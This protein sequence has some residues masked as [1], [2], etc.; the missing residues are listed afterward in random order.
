MASGGPSH[1]SILDE[2][3]P[4]LLDHINIT[5]SGLWDYMVSE[6]VVQSPDVQDIKVPYFLIYAFF[7]IDHCRCRQY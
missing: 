5:T 3:L 6:K 2:N 7:H 1:V 4:E